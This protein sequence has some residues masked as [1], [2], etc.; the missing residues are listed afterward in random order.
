MAANPDKKIKIKEPK[1][2]ADKWSLG[3]KK[4]ECGRKSQD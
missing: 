2:T 1:K 4:Y 3:Y